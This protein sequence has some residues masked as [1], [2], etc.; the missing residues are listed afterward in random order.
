MSERYTKSARDKLLEEIQLIVRRYSIEE[1]L[2]VG[3]IL[4]VI[5]MFKFDYLC[6]AYDMDKE[7]S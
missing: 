5:E 4:A 3:T 2:D 1:D 6:K 7:E